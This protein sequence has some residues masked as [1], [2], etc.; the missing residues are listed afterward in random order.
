[1][2]VLV[3][4]NDPVESLGAYTTLIE[5]TAPVHVV[6]AYRKGAALPPPED[7]TH[8]IVGPT[9]IH[10][11]QYLHYPFLRKVM[12]Y[13]AGYIQRGKPVLGVCCGGQ[14]LALLQGGKVEP[15]P[16]KEVGVYRVSLTPQ[17][18]GDPLFEGFP[19]EFPVFQWHT[20]MFTVPPTG[21]LLVTGSPCP[22]QAYRAQ[23]TWG[24]LFH[25]ELEG[26]DV[27]RWLEAYPEEPSHAGKT[28]Q[29]VWEE[30]EEVS[31]EMLV[32]A[33]LLME[34]FLSLGPLETVKQ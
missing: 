14:L 7:Y 23:N 13:L 20:D 19:R 30:F 28:R 17:G 11:N 32:K 10:A 16:A 6:H 18:R 3:L 27:K 25:L 8:L 24:I 1:M 33:R 21:Q 26:E 15:S 12:K 22:I 31:G 34:N 5:E 2:R 9:P 29:R 4:Q